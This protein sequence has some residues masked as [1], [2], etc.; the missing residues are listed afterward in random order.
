MEL[1]VACLLL[2]CCLL[3]AQASPRWSNTLINRLK[4]YVLQLGDP[5][6]TPHLLFPCSTVCSQGCIAPLAMLGASHFGACH[7]V[8]EE[9]I[10][11]SA[12][13]AHCVHATAESP[14]SVLRRRDSPS[15]ASVGL[16]IAVLSQKPA[17]HSPSLSPQGTSRP[18]GGGGCTQIISAATPIYKQSTKCKPVRALLT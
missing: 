1:V 18:W 6:S 5:N 12:P 9:R 8:W 14:S 10:D 2:A 16:R 11:A 13:R 3:D 7:H 15:L 17:K 4:Y